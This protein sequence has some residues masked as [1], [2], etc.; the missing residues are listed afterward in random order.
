MRDH[1]RAG[2]IRRVD[3]TLA[4]V[5]AAIALLVSGVGGQ[6]LRSHGSIAAPIAAGVVWSAV[7][8]IFGLRGHRWA[9]IVLA[10]FLIVSAF[11]ALLAFDRRTPLALVD[12]AGLAAL[13]IGREPAAA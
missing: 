13:W 2:N 10:I 4:V 3:R 5:V 1:D 7:L 12:V 6:L 11:F 8:L 9:E